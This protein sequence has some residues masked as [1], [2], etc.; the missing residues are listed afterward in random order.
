MDGPRF[1]PRVEPMTLADVPEVS[2]I[3][4]VAFPLSAPI[5]PSVAETELRFREELARPWTYAWVIRD[6][7]AAKVLGYV[8]SWHVADELHVLSVATHPAYRRR[9]LGRTLVERALEFAR[10]KIVKRVFL[11]VRRSNVAAIRLYRAAGFYVLGLRRRYYFDDEDAV[12]MALSLDP[13][14]G[15]VQHRPDEARLDA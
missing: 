9:G 1:A 14:T 7:G 10:S 12:E 4:A 15:R 2:A 8:V 11:E 13:A 3:D 5:H 6:E